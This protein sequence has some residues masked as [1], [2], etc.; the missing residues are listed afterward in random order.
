MRWG[1]RT[2]K[3]GPND[4]VVGRKDDSDGALVSAVLCKILQQLKRRNIPPRQASSVVN[5][6]NNGLAPFVPE[7]C[8]GLGNDVESTLCRVVRVP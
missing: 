3:N 6:K 7:L 4:S 5:H 8:G 1:C 2:A